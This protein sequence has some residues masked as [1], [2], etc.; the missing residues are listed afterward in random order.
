MKKGL[1]ISLI[2]SAVIL[3]AGGGGGYF[4]WKYA[5]S[6][7]IRYSTYDLKRGD[8]TYG[9]TATGTLNDSLVINVGTQVSGI[10]TQIFVDFNDSVRPGQVIAMIDTV[11]LATEVTDAL[12]ALYKARTA[13]AQQQKEFDRYKELL[14]RKAVDQSD[15]DIQE[16]SYEGAVSAV[17]GAQADLKRAKMNLG[18]ATITAPIKGIIINRNVTIGQTVAASFATPTLFSIGNDPHIMQVTASI[19][20]ADIGWVKPG[21]D[22]DFTV[23][24]Y[25][26]RI[27]HGTVFQVRLQSIQNQNVVTYSVMVNLINEDLTLIPGMTATLTIKV[28]EHKNVL[29]VPMT[30]L[31]FDPNPNDTLVPSADHNKQTIWVICDSASGAQTRGRCTD[32]KGTQMYCDTVR[33]I[34]DDGVM[35]EIEGP[36]LHEG[37]QIVTGIVKEQAQKLKSILPS[38]TQQRAPQQPA[39]PGGK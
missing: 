8:I 23:E 22:V 26:D 36:D 12:A 25:P 1:K 39:R 7:K 2:V 27:Y 35:A 32:V 19:D 20:E 28:A 5:K 16:A 11:P 10:I 34:L 14:A 30:A 37:M 33:R 21:Q 9:I 17:Q 24:T 38:T 18:Y 29:V 3:L 15:Y 31:L 4:Y 6:E 13:L